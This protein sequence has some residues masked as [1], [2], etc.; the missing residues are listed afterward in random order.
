MYAAT[1]LST[2]GAVA[3]KVLRMDDP[4]EVVRRRLDRELR[5]MVALKGHPYVVHVEE[6]LDAA[7]GPVL[8]MELAEQGSLAAQVAACGPLSVSDTLLAAHQVAVV[9]RDAHRA[10]IVHRDIKPHN[11]LA[12]RFGSIKVCDFGIAS[13][14]SE[15]GWR[16]RT[17]ALSYRYASPEELADDPAVGPPADV[18]SL[19]VTIRHLLTGSPTAGRTHPRPPAD[20]P[21][22]ERLT[23]LV[24]ACT[25]PQPSDR[26]T[27]S[28]VARWTEEIRSGLGASAED[29]LQFVQEASV[30]AS[31]RSEIVEPT[32]LCR[33]LGRLPVP[34]TNPDWWTM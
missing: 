6:V 19:G 1:R 20:V 33:P 5:A 17:S 3:L 11:V 21:V 29:G 10:G 4:P 24:D 16:D 15:S 25:R 12:T 31:A 34:N 7:D 32:V 18:Y 30:G 13:I 26:P 9:L 28:D 2:G 23:A 14:A 27:A 22:V 8:V